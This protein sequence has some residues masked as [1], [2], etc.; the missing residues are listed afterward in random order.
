MSDMQNIRRVKL[1][2][3]R[4]ARSELTTGNFTQENPLKLKIGAVTISAYVRPH[5]DGKMIRTG[6]TDLLVME[7]QITYIPQCRDAISLV[8]K[9]AGRYPYVALSCSFAHADLDSDKEIIAPL[10][11]Y[12]GLIVDGLTDEALDLAIRGLTHHFL[13]MPVLLAQ[14]QGVQKFIEDYETQM[15]KD[16]DD[17]STDDDDDSTDDD[18]TDDEPPTLPEDDEPT[19]VDSWE[20]EERE[21]ISQT[22]ADC[23]D[24]T[25]INEDSFLKNFSYKTNKD[26]SPQAEECGK[27]NETLIA[28]VLSELDQL[29]GLDAVKSEVKSLVKLCRLN[30]RR[31]ALGLNTEGFAPHLVFSGNPGTGKTTVARIIGDLYR[32]L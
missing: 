32:A 20:Q 21:E 18:S 23:D 8:L 2:L 1:M 28:E 12:S 19:Q 7:V 11:A 25:D 29:V 4:R 24:T 17:E 31:A 30:A 13:E 16:A 14:D 3:T 9:N 5:Y 26:K 27:I 6:G 15:E 22:E 10:I